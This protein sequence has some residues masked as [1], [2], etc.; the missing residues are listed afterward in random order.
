[1]TLF[2]RLRML[3]PEHLRDR[4]FL[5][6]LLFAGLLS[7]ALMGCASTKP[8]QWTGYS[9]HFVKVDS[10]VHPDSS[11]SAWLAAYRAAVN[12]SLGKTIAYSSG[13]FSINE[14]EGTLG[15]LVADAIRD[16]AAL[17]LGRY[18]DM[19]VFSNSRLRFYLP[20]GPVTPFEIAEIMPYDSKVVLLKISGVQLLMLAREIAAS[21]GE[22][23]SG[24]RMSIRNGQPKDVLVGRRL[25]EPDSTYFVATSKFIAD[26]DDLYRALMNPIER[27][28]VGLS[29][30]KAVINYVGNRINIR[31]MLDGRM[32]NPDE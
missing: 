23:V 19:G 3:L 4:R 1:M 2:F 16:Q 6:S 5:L 9:N 26:S 25:I 18:V 21:G 15:D 20:K 27:K 11:V 29:V 8:Y 31:P 30:R 14:P 17:K 24:L 10:T 32:R 22:P 12:D 13:E 28:E 7:M